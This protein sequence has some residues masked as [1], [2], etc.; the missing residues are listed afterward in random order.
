MIL[1]DLRLPQDLCT[2]RMRWD[3]TK[4][5][6]VY[7]LDLDTPVIF[8]YATILYIVITLDEEISKTYLQW[9]CLELKAFETEFNIL[10]IL[11]GCLN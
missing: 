9:K 5:S 2:F 7:T 11:Q 6:R 3:K 8:F 4:V 1:K 10:I